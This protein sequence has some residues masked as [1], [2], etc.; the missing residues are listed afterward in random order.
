MDVDFN[1]KDT[2]GK[3]YDDDED[4]FVKTYPSYEKI[5]QIIPYPS[6]KSEGNNVKGLQTCVVIM[7]HNVKIHYKCNDVLKY[8]NQTSNNENYTDVCDKEYYEDKENTLIMKI[9][10]DVVTMMVTNA[11]ATNNKKLRDYINNNIAG[12]RSYI[13]EK[14][15]EIGAGK[16]IGPPQYDVTVKTISDLIQNAATNAKSDEIRKVFAII[17]KNRSVNSIHA[18]CEECLMSLTGDTSLT[19]EDL[20]KACKMEYYNSMLVANNKELTSIAFPMI[21]YNNKNITIQ[22]TAKWAK[23][24]LIDFE[25]NV[26]VT[27]KTMNIREVWF[28]V[29]NGDVSNTQ[30]NATAFREGFG[31]TTADGNINKGFQIRRGTRR[32]PPPPGA[33]PPGAP[34]PGAPPPG[35]PP[36]GAPPMTVLPPLGRGRGSRTPPQPSST[37]RVPPIG[38]RVTPIVGGKKRVKVN[39][40]GVVH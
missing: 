19:K 21:P 29:D 11:K 20:E 23:E 36:P 16:I 26:R 13:K 25:K 12:I 37:P 14:Y 10:Y 34:P 15:I 17:E 7:A 35:A 3:E 1:M 38:P 31:I 27:A 32:V 8:K 22:E 9:T 24:S 5:G 40:T 6:I 33:P 18:Q 2:F 28:Y 39:T 4:I 30:A